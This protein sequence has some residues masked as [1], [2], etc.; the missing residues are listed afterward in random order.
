[1]EIFDFC[2]GCCVGKNVSRQ[3][4]ILSKSLQSSSLSA[5]EGQDLVTVIIK[6]L[7]EDRKK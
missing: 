6:K 2:F 7:E 3:T 1:M 5:A 4:D